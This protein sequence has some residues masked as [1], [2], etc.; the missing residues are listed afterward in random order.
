MEL[1]PLQTTYLGFRHISVT[2]PKQIKKG[3][4]CRPPSTT[5]L[6]LKQLENERALDLDQAG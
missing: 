3:D 1:L 5:M 2:Y 4:L 6:C